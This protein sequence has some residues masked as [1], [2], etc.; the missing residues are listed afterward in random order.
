VCRW[1]VEKQ[2]SGKIQIL[3]DQIAELEDEVDFLSLKLKE[4]VALARARMHALLVLV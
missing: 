1:Q 3:K 4:E 2:W